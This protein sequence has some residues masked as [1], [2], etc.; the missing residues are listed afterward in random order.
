MPR[1]RLRVQYR[2]MSSEAPSRAEQRASQLKPSTLEG[3]RTRI[4]DA[5]AL[6]AFGDKSRE[7]NSAELH[8]VLGRS[9]ARWDELT[10]FIESTYSPLS[11]SWGFADA[12]WGWSL[13]LKQRKRTVMYLTPCE[14]HFLVGIVLGEKAV[15]AAHAVPLDKSLLALIDAAPKYPE[16]RGVRIEV[17]VKS[18]VESVKQLAAVKMAN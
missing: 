4:G 11:V 1:R 8:Q 18:D 15:Q 16:G 5:V 9:G 3:P 10:A 6:S 13:R 12:K 14:R 7:P 2:S 17:R